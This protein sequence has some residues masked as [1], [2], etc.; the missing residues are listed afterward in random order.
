MAGCGSIGGETYG[1]GI[2]MRERKNEKRKSKG[3]RKRKKKWVAI[4][5]V[6]LYLQRSL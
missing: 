6:L 5:G 4:V 3:K 1:Y 2:G